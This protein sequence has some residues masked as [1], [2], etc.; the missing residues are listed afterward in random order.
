ME[1]EFE[2]IG[3]S[4][5]I[6]QSVLNNLDKVDE[7]INQIASDSEK[8]ATNFTSA[9][10]RMGNGAA[11]LLKRLQDIKSITGSLGDIKIS[12]INNVST[13]M[14]KTATEAEKAANGIA[15]V[16]TSMNQM[17]SG[18]NIAEL[19][20]SIKELNTQ[21]TAGSGIKSMSEQQSVVNK[22]RDLQEELVVQKKSEKQIDEENLK[23]AQRKQANLDK[24]VES[25]ERINK[26]N[27]SEQANNEKDL[28]N[29]VLSKKK[30]QAALEEQSAKISESYQKAEQ[31]RVEDI[32]R[33]EDERRK[34]KRA[35]YEE[36]LKYAQQLDKKEEAAAKK[37]LDEINREY[38]AQAKLDSQLRKLNY[39]SYVTST[40][41]SLRTADK[42]NTY[43]QR[44][45]AIK[46]LEAAIKNLR[47]TDSNYQ[48]D[49]ARLSQAH[50]KLSEEQRKV[51]ANYRNMQ[52]SQRRLMD[53]S[54]Q[55]M[56]QLAL[57]FSVS[58]IEGYV[59]KLVR[60]RGE[61]ELQ[62][63]ALASILQNKDKADRLFAQITELA[64]QSPF[65]VKEL[66]TYTK[67]LSAYSVEYEKLY[68]TTKM[69]ADVSA[70][71][72]VD[73]QRLILAFGQVKAANFLRGCLGYGTPVMLYE[74]TIKQVQDI[75][76]GDVLINEKGEP[77]NV[78]ELIRGRETMFLVEQVSGH[79]RTS[80]RVNR[81]HILTLWN[82][83]EQ[84]LED[85]YV[86]DY[87]KNTEA[88][89]G[90]RIVDGEKVYYD[91]EVTKD[92]IDDYYGFVLDGNK[93]FRLGDGTITHNTETRQ[94]TEAGINMLGE[95]SKYYTELEGR[96]VSV[97]EVQDR[98]FKRMISFQDV[99][100]VFK[101]LTSAG[102][103]FYNM[104]E[105]QA[106]TLAG[107]M[108][109]L[110]DRIDLML[111]SI[112][113][114][115]EGVIK[116]VVRILQDLLSN[117][118]VLVEVIKTAGA[119]FL[120]YRL[121]VLASRDSI[122]LLAIEH[123]I[124]TREFPKSLSLLQLMNLGFKRLTTSVKA[125]GAAMKAFA[126]SN[127]YL[128]AIS[129]IVGGIYELVTWNDEYNEQLDDINKQHNRMSANLIKIADEY[130]NISRKA[131]EAADSQKEFAYSGDTYKEL[132]AQLSKLNQELGDRG[133]SLPIPLEFV[134]PENIDDVFKGGEELLEKA[135]DFSADFK[136]A[137][138]EE[139]TAT[140][141]GGIFGENLATDLEDLSES[142]GEFLGG[143]IKATL[144]EIENEVTVVSGKLVGAAK[145]YY[146]E[147]KRGK[148]ETETEIEWT[149]RRVQLLTEINNLTKTTTTNILT[150]EVITKSILKSEN[151]LLEIA[152]K[153]RDIA[154][155]E[156]EA[157][158]ELDKV[159][160]HLIKRYGSL[161]NFKREYNE[162]PIVISAEIDK[163]FD[164]LELELD[165]QTKR[166]ASK[167]LLNKLQIPVEFVVKQDLPQFFGDFRDTVKALDTEG[168]FKTDLESMSNLSELQDEIQ[169][170]Y[171]EI[172]KQLEVVNNAN[173]ESLDLTEQ[174]RIEK[175]KMLSSDKNEA[176][177]AA[178]RV[179]NLESQKSALDEYIR[180]ER[181][182]LNLSKQSVVNM[183]NALGLSYEKSTTGDSNELKLLKDQIALIKKARD[184]YKKLRQVYSEEEATKIIREAY[185]DAFGNLQLSTEMTFDVD[186][187]I[188]ALKNLNYAVVKG[189][190]EAVEA[191]VAPLEAQRNVDV[192]IEGI[193][194]LKQQIESIFD[195]YDLYLELEKLGVSPQ[196]MKD[197][198]GFNFM[199]LKDVENEIKKYESK[200]EKY[201]E[202]GE[203]ILTDAEKRVTDAHKSE[204]E[205]R[206]KDYI[207]Y[208]QNSVS[209]RASIEIA[210]QKEIAKIR[211][212]KDLTEPVKSSLVEIV[213]KQLES[214]R[215]KVLWDDFKSS[216]T[217][218]KMFDDL[219][220][221]ST[222]ALSKLKENLDKVKESLGELEPDQV[223]A[224]VEAYNKIESQLIS[225]NPFD[226]FRE[227]MKKIRRLK[228][229][230][231]SEEE[232]QKN[233]ISYEYDSSVLKSQIADIETI[234]SLKEEGLKLD[235]LDAD[236]QERN[237]DYL[238]QNVGYLRS[239]LSGKKTS[240]SEVE[241]NIG[242]TNKQLNTYAKARQSISEMASEIDSVVSLAKKAFGS[243]T[244]T[245]EA[246]GVEADSNA[247]I[248]AEMGMSMLDV[249]LN[250][251]MFG[252]QL[253]ALQAEAVVLGTTLDAAL[254]PIGW[255]VLAIEAIAIGLTAIFKAKDNKLQKQIDA[256]MDG[257]ERLQTAFEGL[258]RASERAFNS[259]QMVSYTNQMIE[260]LQAQTAALNAAKAAEE[261][262]KNSDE[263]AVKDYD[264]QIRENIQ[265]QEDL[266][267]ELIQSLG[268]TGGEANYLSAAEEF[269]D[270][271]RT[272]F[273][274]TG[275][276]LDGLM[277]HFD[278]FIN[279]IIYKQAALRYL[280]NAL[281]PLFDDID[282]MFTAD[283]PYGENVST[284]EI[285]EII[286]KYGNAYWEAVSAG[287]ENF[288]KGFDFGGLSKGDTLSGL[289]ESISSITEETAQ[290]LEALLNSM[291]Y[292]VADS[293]LQLRN[294]YSVLN[295]PSAENPY[296][297]QMKIQSEQLKM[298][299]SLWTSMSKTKTGVSGKVL[300]VEI[301]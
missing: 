153:R 114:E 267:N 31:K 117:Y 149:L 106:E 92:R 111:N 249:V 13:E 94:F 231:L 65:T 19:T 263:E 211:A 284:D 26:V 151:K 63:T 50:K 191:A 204:L 212:N 15:K 200:L 110:Q 35:S 108:S 298:I 109:N 156:K 195:S 209:K 18:M 216:E 120:L 49:L 97:Q 253:K 43:T 173:T 293:N 122:R 134:T 237:K 44:A 280:N 144:D 112:G 96:I 55:L 29:W 183:A 186:G 38:Q 272:A 240:L 245:L 198:F 27:S 25:Y 163:T 223:E 68:D 100:Q 126:K 21:L 84:R 147:L 30:E 98:Q 205:K 288:I 276:G 52:T 88:Y 118:D 208:I 290:A 199:S 129:A 41:G 93:R 121:N 59:N 36:A 278:E 238:G 83:Q 261:D 33:Q 99:E 24:L 133:Y 174:I 233:L 250:A 295:N 130:D 152:S 201:G 159:I 190:E 271:W 256:L 155:D 164:E 185:K 54:G 176:N 46:N 241:I 45:Q 119:A 76:V 127:I 206:M 11:D 95:L 158:H 297:S 104:Q 101:R 194:K 10:T 141:A 124:L 182:R 275:D 236:F 137:L 107:M 187:V 301:V 7:K 91:I 255:I 150:G 222:A 5:Q 37:R 48:K 53:T 229:E 57:V 8:M 135:N 300:K 165:A 197:L 210:A 102:G 77:V 74:G 42:A 291:R 123:G 189:G 160:E 179:K 47:T 218:T 73:M 9:M 146:E 283:S 148:N 143:G 162:N 221:V 180:S 90:L 294:I 103:M 181:E 188:A 167:Y 235:N 64:I 243:I 270:A 62:N 22:L 217:Y 177:A 17:G 32:A 113:K 39:Q 78:L 273:E 257:V 116:G 72:G 28:A 274:E 4:L 262:K 282:K 202:G 75:V 269:L 264:D 171:S 203:K 259:E 292:Y 154:V 299:Y 215:N 279:D 145:D 254:G 214:D 175:E 136:K 224:I 67:S 168:L 40:E 281:Q 69:L 166:F 56:R 268:G 20:A 251:V 248:F 285:N 170:K 14:G 16:A 61:F 234:I 85:V 157:Q 178:L 244:S 3:K 230:G 242:I 82:V 70:G 66:T 228:K 192:R 138:A 220:Y 58:Q 207:A 239:A 12:G 225:R 140:E 125:A 287:L 87:L 105:T 196:V 258:E 169:K 247:M 139:L 89:L 213:K 71:L 161:E 277:E 226:S 172:D 34:A 286:S 296:L 289:S 1:E 51:E 6:P 132:F 246:A 115:N 60:V 265:K 252:L 80:Y 131:R 193:D 79:N 232:L 2:G 142:Y 184:E 227:A 266:R 260:N 219:E 81:N 86:Y 23:N 128:I